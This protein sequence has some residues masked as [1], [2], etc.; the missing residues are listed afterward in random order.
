MHG[1]GH[2]VLADSAA[3]AIM[4][5]RLSLI[6]RRQLFG[7]TFWM[8]GVFSEYNMGTSI[9][10]FY[11][12]TTG[13][14]EAA[15]EAIRD[16][17]GELVT[18]VE[19]IDDTKPEDF[20]EYDVLVFGISTWNIGELQSDWEYFLPKMEGLDLTGKKI[21]LFGLG[22]AFGYSENFLDA[23]GLLWDE[24]KK[25]GDPQLIGVWPTEGYT[26][27]ESVGK[28]DDDNFLGL[29]LDE[30][31]EPDLHDERIK[32]WVGKVKSELNLS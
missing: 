29:G 10:L 2:V 22:D 20:L 15:A 26:F 27:D 1:L 31:N 5:M 18:H 17:F 8:Q 7:F 6:T 23:L 25:C 21:A 19:N 3:D 32:A 11:G 14:T 24:V 13:N 9:A 28:Y 30:D 12:S 16:E 4:R